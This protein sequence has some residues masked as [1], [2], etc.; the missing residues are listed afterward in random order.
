M[1]GV[2]VVLGIISAAAIPLSANSG[3]MIRAGIGIIAIATGLLI[4]SLA[5][6]NFA[7]MDWD[8]MGKGLVGIG[9]G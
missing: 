1:V 6:K 3:G 8:E 5:V 9:V 7:D 4:L 2:G